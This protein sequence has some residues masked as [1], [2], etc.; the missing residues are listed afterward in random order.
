MRHPSRHCCRKFSE[1]RILIDQADLGVAVFALVGRADL[2]AQMMDDILQPITNSEDGKTEIENRGIGWG[3]IGVID[4][5]GT[6]RK[7]DADRAVRLNLGDRGSTGKD[8]G[9]DV[10]LS[11]PPRDQL[12]VLRAEVEDDD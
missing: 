1:Q 10:L 6:A 11:Y 2:A 8:D 4:R 3:R 12:G 7:N 5:A 9:E